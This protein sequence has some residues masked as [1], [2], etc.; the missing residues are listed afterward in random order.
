[1]EPHLNSPEPYDVV[2][3]IVDRISKAQDE[4]TLHVTLPKEIGVAVVKLLD[5]H[6]SVE[7]SNCRVSYDSVKRHLDVLIRPSPIQN[8]HMGWIH[9]SLVALER[10]GRITAAEHDLLVL[11]SNTSEYACLP[12]NLRSLGTEET[13]FLGMY[14][15]SSKEPDTTISHQSLLFPNVVVESGWSE[16]LSRLRSDKTLWIN[17]GLGRVLVVLIIKWTAQANNTVAGVIEVWA[18]D[19]AGNDSLVQT[20]HVFPAPPPQV[21]VGQAIYVTRGQLFGNVLDP[22]LN[23]ADVF[24]FRIDTLRT[25][26]TRAL[27]KMGLQPA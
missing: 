18:G 8:V 7:A 5:K 3:K 21:A 14:A 20:E 25:L 26:A 22:G 23:P 15:G 19:A 13:E 6:P 4:E 24:E 17:G 9:R 16:S 12:A 10:S 27:E 11:D 1:M 2:S